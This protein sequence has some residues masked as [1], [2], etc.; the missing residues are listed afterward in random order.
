M[1]FAITL[2]LFVALFSLTWASSP[3]RSVIVSY[4]DDTPDSVLDEAKSAVKQA[5]G[6]ITHEYSK[7]ILG[8][9][10]WG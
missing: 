5:G 10:V 8:A 2:L 9:S 3:Q 1:K 4:Q 6:L 7:P